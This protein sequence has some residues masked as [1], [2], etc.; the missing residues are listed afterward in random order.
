MSWSFYHQAKSKKTLI[1]SVLWFLYDFFVYKKVA[2]KKS[3]KETLFL[4]APYKAG[5]GAGPGAGSGFGF[6][7]ISGSVPKFY[8]SVPKCY[9]SIPKCC[10]ATTVL[11]R[12]LASI[13][14]FDANLDPDLDRHR[15]GNSYP[16]RH[17]NYADPHIGRKPF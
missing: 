10:G 15:N 12:H 13:N 2:S 4:L 9:G 14:I 3:G 11:K 16:D 5:S 1:T 7:A 17:Q 8:G 6:S